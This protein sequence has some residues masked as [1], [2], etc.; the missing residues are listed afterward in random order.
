[1]N[2]FYVICFFL[3]LWSV[4]TGFAQTQQ[5][6]T[7]QQIISLAK[8]ESQVSL[9][10]NNRKENLYWQYRTFLSNYK[11]QLSLTGTLPNYNK[12]IER[13]TLPTGEDSF[14]PR[15]VVNT[16]VNLE[17]RQSIGLTGGEVFIN[18]NLARI[19]LIG[20]QTGTSFLSTPISIGFR[21][22]IFGFNQLKWD[23]KIEP[24]KYD[25]SRKAFSEDMERI[26]V[27]STDLFFNLLVAQI[28]LR[29][30]ELNK[31]NNDTIYKIAQGRYNVGKI[32]EN[33]LLQLQ[34]NSMQ[35]DQQVTQAKLD[36][37]TSQLSLKIFLGNNENLKD[38]QLLAPPTIPDLTIDESLALSEAKKNRA[39]YVQFRRQK[40]EAERDI[41]RA[42]GNSGLNVNLFGSY[43]FTQ[44]AQDFNNVYRDPQNQQR[45]QIGFQIPIL[46]WGR[47]KSTIQTAVAN[48]KLVQSTVAQNELNFEQEIILKV[49][50]FKIFRSR[51]IIAQKADDIAQRRYDIAQ[52]RYL[53]AKINITDLNI[54]L[55]DK[56]N[57]K[58]GYLEALRRFWKN[59]YEIRQLTLYDFEKNEPIRY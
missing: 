59:Y 49:K 55:Q 16:D 37:E 6:Y 50:Q 13:I 54:A 3:G 1:M 33:E 24:L 48:N 34:L 39:R 32:A 51:L 2:R 56:D 58:R 53:I 11:P 27:Q 19:D 21:Q 28:T 44:N 20:D 22:P 47:Q 36:I 4:Q 43:G 57:A 15:G 31:A 29:I 46:D 7:L 9:Q 8:K 45:L 12:S 26:A 52:K 38:I 35:S 23:K 10:A 30:S 42:R 40:I 18:T 17:L 41:A 25:E 5:K 14:V